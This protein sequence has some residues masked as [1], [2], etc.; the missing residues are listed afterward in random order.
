MRLYL[1]IQREETVMRTGG[2]FCA[3][4]RPQSALLPITQVTV[5]VLFCFLE[6]T[7]YR[8]MDAC[9][10]MNTHVCKHTSSPNDTQRKP[11]P[12]NADSFTFPQPSCK[13][14]LNPNCTRTAGSPSFF[15]FLYQSKLYS[16]KFIILTILNV[17]FTGIKYIQT[18]QHP[19]PEL[20]II[21]KRNFTH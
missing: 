3:I 8:F 1:N 12:L 21:P 15:I 2:R 9:V 13:G 14:Y 10:N 20:F 7:P 11:Q 17:Q 5:L 16:V 18:V 6:N 4:P 19:S